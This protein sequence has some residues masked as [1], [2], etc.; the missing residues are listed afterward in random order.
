MRKNRV[1]V[2]AV[3]VLIAGFFAVSP[4]QEAKAAPDLPDS[5]ADLVEKLGPTVVNIYT[6]QVVKLKNSPNE[7]FFH[8]DNELP[9]MFK[10]FFGLPDFQDRAPAPRREMKKTSL[11]SGVIISSVGYIITNNYVVLYA[12]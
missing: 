3:L 11:G 12:K 4:S 5:F 6:T 9:E 2:V 7:F 1:L 10:R 8:G